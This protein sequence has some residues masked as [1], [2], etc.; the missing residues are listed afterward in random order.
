MFI[1]RFE[2]SFTMSCVFTKGTPQYKSQK[3]LKTTCFQGFL[4]KNLTIENR[5]LIVFR[6]LLRRF[7]AKLRV[8]N[9]N[10]YFRF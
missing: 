3:A 7:F 6:N 5:L 10:Y 2:N 1:I 4:A 8:L 9:L